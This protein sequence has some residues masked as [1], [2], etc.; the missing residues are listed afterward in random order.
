MSS[1]WPFVAWGKDV[2]GPIEPSASNG[3]RFILVAI[4]Y[5]IKWV[6]AASYKSVWDYAPKLN[7]LSSPYDGAVESANKNIKKILRKMIDNHREAVIPVEIEIPSLRIIQEAELSNAEWVRKRID[8]LTLID[9]NRMVVVCHGQL[10]RQRMIRAFHKRVRAR[11]F[12]VGQLVLKRIFPHQDEYKGKFA[13]NWQGPYM[14]RKVLSG[15]ALVL[16]EMD[17]TAWAK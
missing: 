9:E 6:E 1:P 11:I 14:V 5:F 13:P 4:D 2:I 10:Y 3:H 17:G 12:E 15:G 8:Q 7:R 16:S